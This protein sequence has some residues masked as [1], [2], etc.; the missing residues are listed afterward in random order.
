MFRTYQHV[1]PLAKAWRTTIDKPLTR[2]FKG[3]GKAAQDI[4]EEH[5]DVFNDLYPQTTRAIA[6]WEFE[7]G[8]T[9]T[10]L[11]EQQR[12]DRLSAAWKAQGGQDPEYIQ[13]TLQ[14]NG[15]D[16]YVHDWW[17][18]GS[19][20]AVGVKQC[21]TP[22]NPRLYLRKEF[23][24]AE[25]LAECGE[26]FAEC[27]EPFME[28]GESLQPQGYLL[29]NK[30][31]ST[32]ADSITLC[33]EPFM[34]CGESDAECGNFTEYVQS[35]REY[36]VPNDP[37]KWP[38]FFYIG[39]QTFGDLAQVPQSRRNEFEALCLKICPA[40]LWLGLLVEYV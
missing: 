6:E 37:S 29:V 32:V 31:L 10:G 38:F 36:I 2:F 17:E 19:E 11:T 28:C 22:R 20:P 25:L 15:F 30:T 18:P 14:N 4:R 27:G 5:D 16:V 21:V 3:L 34:E 1:L 40:H 26:P 23:T 9:S 13:T 8:L 7:F 33:G 39:G 35:A 24:Q 12:R